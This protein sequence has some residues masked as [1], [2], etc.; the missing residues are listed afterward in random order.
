MLQ[1]TQVARVVLYWPR[2]LSRFRTVRDL[3]AATEDEVLGAWS[4]LGYYRRARMLHRAAAVV[5]GELSGRIPRSAA[6]LVRL[7]GV[8]AYTAAAVASIA[9]GEP[10]P[11][12]DANVVRVLARLV[13][14]RGDPSR[15]ALR[16][17]LASEARR[18][19]DASRP[20]DWNQAVMELGA[21]VC[22]AF[23]PGCARCPVA[24]F[25]RAGLS[26][27]PTRYPGAARP[28]KG[29]AIREVVAVIERRGRILLVRGGH[30]RGWWEGLWMLPRTALSSGDDPAREL[31]RM[32]ARRHGLACALEGEPMR[33]SYSVTKHRVA[34]LVVRAGSVSGRVRAG[35]GGRW[36]PLSLLEHVAIPAPDR[37]I[38]STLPRRTRR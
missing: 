7:P 19:L 29:V 17:R 38:L 27:A 15:G 22:T 6:G 1:Q 18:L 28:T 34:A 31:R 20:G 4:G 3:A 25:C 16:K 12:L 8:G 9:Y 37:S 24:R 23:D 32:L 30:E 21:L 35:S 26:G 36:L 5:V 10:A 2:F 13:G 33:R 11:V 14:A